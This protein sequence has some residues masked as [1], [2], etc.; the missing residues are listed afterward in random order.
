MS[1]LDLDGKV[2]IVTGGAGGIGTA[3]ATAFSKAG[4]KVV[5]SS[6]T[7]DNLEKVASDLRSSGGEALAVACD[8]TAPEQVDQL[9]QQTL[10]T[11]GSIDILVN[12]AGGAVVIKDPDVMTPDEWK[13]VIDLNL[14][15]TFYC[16]SAAGR[17]MLKQKS[18]RI[19]NIASVAGIKG[20]STMAPYAAAK[21]A[22]INLTLSLANGWA[23]SNIN[24]NCIAPGLTATPGLTRMGWIPPR[25]QE[26][27]TVTPLLLHPG[28]PERVA[29][30]ALFLASPA[31]EYLSGELFPIRGRLT[32][33]R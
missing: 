19:I 9:M 28:G 26:D 6:R 18:G 22:V 33:D 31:S 27:G 16:A 25:E 5:V 10:D 12:N 23:E 29:D 20:T 2:A 13:S 30:L 7:L 1:Q 3:I 4:A 11:Y 21:A 14:N 24:V 15:G 17:T 8:V 32:N